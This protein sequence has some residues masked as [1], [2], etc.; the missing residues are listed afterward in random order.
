MWPST[1][2]SNCSLSAARRILAV[3]SLLGLICF[4]LVYWRS[5]RYE[6][7]LVEAER[8]IDAGQPADASPWLVLPE[9]HP[10]TRDRALLL[11]ARA[12]LAMGRP[13]EAV[14]PLE[15]LDPNGHSESD[16]ATRKDRALFQVRR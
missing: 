3:M 4:A 1:L 6:R 7:N 11:R 10:T 13:S 2:G 8:L 16:E 5:R 15:K 9:S 12:A 14:K